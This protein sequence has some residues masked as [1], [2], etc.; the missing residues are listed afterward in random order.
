MDI[1]L[2][3]KWIDGKWMW[4][5]DVESGAVPDLTYVWKPRTATIFTDELSTWITR[6]DD[7]LSGVVIDVDNLFRR[8]TEV[9]NLRSI[10]VSYPDNLS[11][12]ITRPDQLSTSITRPDDK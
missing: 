2:D 9:D 6:P 3:G 12:S 5:V 11:T 1:E 4:R 8:L 10:P 7:K